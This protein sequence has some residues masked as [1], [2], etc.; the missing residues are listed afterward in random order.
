MAE[1]PRRPLISA[2][3]DLRRV[4]K[5]DMYVGI[6]L[7]AVACVGT[8]SRRWDAGEEAVRPAAPGGGGGGRA[9]RARDGGRAGAREGGG[10]GADG[11]GPARTEAG[12]WRRASGAVVEVDLPLRFGTAVGVV[13]E[14]GLLVLLFM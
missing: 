1:Q 13:Y 11:G 5:E 14:N 4:F 9:L 6:K 12:S 2:K 10:A 3:L 7:A 8:R